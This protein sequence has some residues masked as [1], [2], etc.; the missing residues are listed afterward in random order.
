MTQEYHW[1]WCPICRTSWPCTDEPCRPDPVAE[2]RAGKPVTCDLCLLPEREAEEL[3]ADMGG[4][5][6]GA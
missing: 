3:Y 5:G 6:G 1:H 2:R 4:E